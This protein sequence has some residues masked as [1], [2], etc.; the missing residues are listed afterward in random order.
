MRNELVREELFSLQRVHNL[1]VYVK[2]QVPLCFYLGVRV[3]KVQKHP[4]L[5]GLKPEDHYLI[6]VVYIHQMFE[7]EY[8]FN[9][10]LL[11]PQVV[12]AQSYDAL[13]IVDVI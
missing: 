6:E 9:L 5:L 3:L 10:P 4:V 7:I 8:P 2:A 13:V 12:L 11:D 1:P